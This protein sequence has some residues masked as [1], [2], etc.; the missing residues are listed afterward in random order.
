MQ[1]LSSWETRA[2]HAINHENRLRAMARLMKAL[3]EE[4]L[5]VFGRAGV[6]PYSAWPL[7]LCEY[8]FAFPVRLGTVSVGKT[9]CLVRGNEK[10][11]ARVVRHGLTTYGSTVADLKFERRLGSLPQMW[12]VL[13]E[14]ELDCMNGDV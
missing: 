3:D 10:R 5:A 2:L 6:R 12:G 13:G 1:R 11:T 4:E 7:E 8:A 14:A 9:I